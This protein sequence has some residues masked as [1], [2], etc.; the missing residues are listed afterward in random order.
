MTREDVPDICPAEVGARYL[1]ISLATWARWE[2]AGRLPT[3]RLPRL[4]HAV[5]YCGETLRRYG[6]PQD[7]KERRAALLKR[8]A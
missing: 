7:I 2:A 8:S 3:H 1:R 4:G 6:T 5:R